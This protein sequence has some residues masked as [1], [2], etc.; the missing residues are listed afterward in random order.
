MTGSCPVFSSPQVCLQLRQIEAARCSG[1][2][3]FF[4]DKFRTE[5]SVSLVA[6]GRPEAPSHGLQ[7]DPG[8]DGETAGVISDHGNGVPTPG[9]GRAIAS[10]AWRRYGP[11]LFVAGLSLPALRQSYSDVAAAEDPHRIH[12]MGVIGGFQSD[13]GLDLVTG[14]ALLPPVVQNVE[15]HG[16]VVVGSSRGIVAGDGGVSVDDLLVGRGDHFG[17]GI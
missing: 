5:N 8:D 7:G 12:D 13:E 4:R 9:A 6:V 3:A 10:S 15:F 2:A 16:A 11:R 1:L 14:D 17:L